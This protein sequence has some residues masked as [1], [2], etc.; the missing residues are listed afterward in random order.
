MLSSINNAINERFI[1]LREWVN[2][3]PRGVQAVLV[4]AMLAAVIAV[5][6][7]CGA[8]PIYKQ[9]PFPRK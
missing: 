4:L 7:W 3:L 8:L 9:V 5:G 1:Q 2:L 6:Y